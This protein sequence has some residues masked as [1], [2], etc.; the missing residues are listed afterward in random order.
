MAQLKQAMTVPDSG[1]Y[2]AATVWNSM[3]DTLQKRGIEGGR[4][5]FSCNYALFIAI[6]QT[7]SS[8]AAKIGKM[9]V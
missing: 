8:W 5:W 2:T 1:R 7:T 9:Q 3:P 6:F 4:P